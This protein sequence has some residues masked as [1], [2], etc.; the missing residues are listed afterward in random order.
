MSLEH[1]HTLNPVT[2][3]EFFHHAGRLLAL[4]GEGTSLKVFEVDSGKLIFQSQIFEAQTVHGIV[5][6]PGARSDGLQLVV[7]G[8]SSLVLLSASTLE[9]ILSENVPRI[10][11]LEVVTA[12]WILDVVIDPSHQGCVLVTAHNTLC[13]ARFGTGDNRIDFK[14]LSSPS[15]SILYSAHLIYDTAEVI[16]VAA[17]TVF[18]EIIVWECYLPADK[19]S[20]GSRVLCTLTGHEGSIFGVN[21]SPPV[22]DSHGTQTRLLASC[23]D[24]RT[25][26]LWDIYGHS[27]IQPSSEHTRQLESAR[28][29]GFGNTGHLGSE[30]AD[31]CLAM[32]MGHASRIWGV[33]FHQTGTNALNSYI[34]INILSFGEDSTTQR[35]ALGPWQVLVNVSKDVAYT[36]RKLHHVD[37]FAYHQGKHIFCQAI[38]ELGTSGTLLATGGA[39]GRIPLYRI[40]VSSEEEVQYHQLEIKKQN[41]EAIEHYTKSSDSEAQGSH[42]QPV[43]LS[44]FELEEILSIFPSPIEELSE[45]LEVNTTPVES[46]AQLAKEEKAQNIDFNQGQRPQSVGSDDVSTIKKKKTKPRKIQK[47]ALN[48]YDFVTEDE[49]ILTTTF[50][51]VLYCSIGTKLQWREIN[52]HK[53][54]RDALKSY[55]VVR[56]SPQLNAVFFASAGGD[57]YMYRSKILSSEKS[58]SDWDTKRIVGHETSDPIVSEN[59]E[60]SE[61][62]PV[63]NLESKVA[64]LVVVTDL[65]ASILT[66]FAIPITGLTITRFSLSLSHTYKLLEKTQMQLPDAFVVTSAQRIDLYTVLGARNGS[67]SV[68]KDGQDTPCCLYPAQPGEKDTITTIIN[69][70]A[71]MSQAGGASFLTTCRNGSFSIFT[72]SEKISSSATDSGLSISRVHHGAPPFGPMIESAWFANGDLFLYGFRSK[73][74]V[75]WNETQQCQVAE[76]ECGGAHRTYA[77]SPPGGNN[78]G[79]HFAYTKASKL[80][81]HTQKGGSHRFI[82]DGGHGREIKSSAV[83][84]DGKMIATGAEDTMIRLWRYNDQGATLD[85]RFESLAVIKKH[86]TGIQHLQWHGSSYLFSSGGTEEFYVWAITSIP[87]F[88][89]GIVRESACPDRS[90][91][92]DLRITSFDVSDIPTPKADKTGLIISIAYSDSTIRTYKY[93]KGTGFEILST[94]RYTS[95]CLTQLRHVYLDDEQLSILT[96]ATDGKISTW[97]AVLSGAKG[98]TPSQLDLISTHKLHQNSIKALDILKLSGGRFIIGTGGDDNAIGITVYSRTTLFSGTAPSR[99]ILPSAHAAAV[100]GLAFVPGKEIQL[101]SSGNDQRVKNWHLSINEDSDEITRFSNAGDAFTSVADVGDLSFLGSNDSAGTTSKVLVVGVGM[102]VWRVSSV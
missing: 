98:V 50:G 22:V 62:V 101:V 70:Q 3:L 34:S 15:R 29:T 42:E 95:I 1:D 83:S 65:E 79:G 10:T 78:K 31:A 56:G 99:T 49:L 12:D 92:G 85:N 24:D 77:Y 54:E 47:D 55:T 89:I 81:I 59:L 88:G 27:K 45:G 51:R 7:W 17:G 100:T 73:Y 5:L 38:R 4:A 102:D 33:R 63:G 87:G 40:P 75:I 66:L 69:V 36:P 68:Y 84:P 8:G 20:A 23:S 90:A 53:S 16:L 97:K 86:T 35:W 44:V 25:I 39:D 93:G 60:E 19:E 46:E 57:I 52:C 37:T 82:K 72:I 61:L 58:S 2:A 43:R 64:D 14:S 41:A 26:R 74:F 94:G 30:V 18:G 13:Q 71:E 48:R 76:I 28:E 96:A 80:Y 32:C 91:D 6:A 67:I 11:E 21:I 9:T